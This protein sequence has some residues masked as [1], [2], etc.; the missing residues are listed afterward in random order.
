M[1]LR[2]IRSFIVLAEE[3]HFGRA[4]T[5]LYLAQPAL[6]QQI[7]QLEAELGVR[8]FR[9]NSH[10]VSLSEEGH[11]FLPNARNALASLV[12]GQEQLQKREQGI[13]GR[14]RVGFISTAALTLL[15]RILHLLQKKY[16]GIDLDLYEKDAHEQL[17][18]LLL[19]E[20]DLGVMHADLR[21]PA[22]ES[23]VAETNTVLLALPAK[24]PLAHHA[25][26]NLR[27][28]AQ[29]RFIL[30]EPLPHEDFREVALGLCERAGF[31]PEHVQRVRMLQ[32][33]V[34][35]VASGAGC[36]LLPSNFQSIRP[37]SVKFCRLRG[38]DSK[39]PL[40]LTYRRDV[41]HPLVRNVVDLIS[42]SSALTH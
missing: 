39:L 22:L 7:R 23:F 6:S 26:V 35:L 2:H 34:S 33:A 13:S 15:P 30:P 28:L 29:E 24:H 11:V 9:R 4:A 40:Y 8:L 12:M 5:R 25:S 20:L 37:R 18:G 27:A 17:Q 42:K 21:H 14:V 31:V 38:T 36:A 41:K 10:S 3:L 32:T 19:D 1:E 16:P